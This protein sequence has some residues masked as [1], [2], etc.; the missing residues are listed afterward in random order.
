MRAITGL[1]GKRNRDN[2]KVTT[3][4]ATIGIRGSGFNVGYNP[5]GS[6][7]V[8]TELDAIEVCNAGGCVGLTAGE[9]VRVVSS[10]EAPVR[11]NTRAAVPTP[12]SPEQEPTVAGNQTNSEGKAAIVTTDNKVSNNGTFS[13]LMVAGTY[14]VLPSPGTNTQIGPVTASSATI[15]DGKLSGFVTAGPPVTTYTPSTLINSGSAGSLAAN[16]FIG[17]GTWAS[18]TKVQT[19]TTITTNLHYIVGQPTVTMPGAGAGTLTYSFT[20]GS[21]VTG[22]NGVNTP[23]VGSLTSASLVANFGSNSVDVNIVTSLGSVSRTGIGLSGSQ[24]NYTGTAV[25]LAGFFVGTN[26][27]RAGLV[28]VGQLTGGTMSYETFSGSASFKAP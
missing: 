21:A 28:Y 12:A 18:G 10:Q 22:Y 14:V 6:L 1:I 9:S 23:L 24:F 25:S 4:T 2:Y 15:T 7:G 3:T 16:D 17:W 19:G 13:N 26:A 5:D 8:T 11:T 27:S 20:G